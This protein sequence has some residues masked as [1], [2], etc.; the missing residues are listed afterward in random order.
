[1][2]DYCLLY[3]VPGLVPSFGAYLDGPSWNLMLTALLKGNN[4][5]GIFGNKNCICVVL[6]FVIWHDGVK[7]TIISHCL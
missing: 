5:A 3:V 4:Q 6:K 7:N 2:F 1:M